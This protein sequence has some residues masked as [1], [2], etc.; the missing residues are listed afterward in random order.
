MTL[1][2]FME[3]HNIYERQRDVGGNTTIGMLIG[4]AEVIS[5]QEVFRTMSTRQIHTLLQ[6]KIR[7]MLRSTARL[8]LDALEELEGTD[9]L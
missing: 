9:L 4:A 6:K 3:K 7:G 2:K 8:V 5:R 1:K